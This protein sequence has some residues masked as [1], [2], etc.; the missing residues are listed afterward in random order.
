MSF[1]L[2]IILTIIIYNVYHKMFH[3]TYFGLSAF[4]KEIVGIFVFSLCISYGLL[5]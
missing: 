2:S 1:I 5:G 4:F 3:V